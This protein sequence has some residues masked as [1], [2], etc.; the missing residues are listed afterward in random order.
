[1]VPGVSARP[2]GDVARQQRRYSHRRGLYL[3]VEEAGL[4]N[5]VALWLRD[6][7]AKHPKR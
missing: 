5:S 3:V 6:Q 7:T 4:S 2:G 1:M